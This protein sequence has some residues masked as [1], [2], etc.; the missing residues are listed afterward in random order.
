MNG[1]CRHCYPTCPGGDTVSD[2]VGRWVKT[3]EHLSK[4]LETQWPADDP[5]PLCE[6]GA[7]ETP[8]KPLPASMFELKWDFARS[9]K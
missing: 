8:V 7:P 5:C 2:W 4:D 9:D 3:F 6:A 1:H